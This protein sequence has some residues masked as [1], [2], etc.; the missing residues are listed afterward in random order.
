MCYVCSVTGKKTRE[1]LL[2]K[3]YG[4]SV[5]AIPEGQHELHALIN[6]DEYIHPILYATF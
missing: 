3:H 1:T 4:K 5:S 2:K 6:V